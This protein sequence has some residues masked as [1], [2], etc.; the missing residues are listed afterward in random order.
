M[1]RVGADRDRLKVVEDQIGCP[2]SATDL[3]G[4]LVFI[5][6]RMADDVTVPSG[7]FHFNNAGAVSWADF[8]IEIF[9]QSAA[10]RGLTSEV[11]PITT[12]EYSSLARR[13]ANSLLSH[14]AIQATYGI[15]ASMAECAGRHTR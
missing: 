4:A 10:R 1:L 15:V 9:C 11:A 5:A 12:A 13:P 6:M 3:A 7:T 8:A 2:T 14:A